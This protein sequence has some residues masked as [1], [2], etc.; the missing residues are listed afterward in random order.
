MMTEEEPKTNG[1]GTKV[2]PRRSRE[3][4]AD[5]KVFVYRLTD[6]KPREY[7]S[8]PESVV[9]EPLERRLLPFLEERNAGAGDYKIE[10]RKPN[11]RFERSYDFTIASDQAEP[12][13]V[14][15]VDSEYLNDDASENS[16]ER[17]LDEGEIELRAELLTL[18]RELRELRD[19]EKE[20]VGNAK[21]SQSEMLAM[22]RESAKQSEASFQRGL[23]MAKMIMQSSQPREDATSQ[24]MNIL[25]K[26]LG[27]VTKAKAI[28]EEIAPSD[29]GS[30]GGGGLLADGAKLL[31]SVGRNAGTLLPV[32][33]GFLSRPAAVSQPARVAPAPPAIQMSIPAVDDSGELNDLAAKIRQKKANS[34]VEEHERQDPK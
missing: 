31:D 27:I 15:D 13:R 18:R 25:E 30:G 26:S 3:P 33:G 12:D 24:A 19:K 10:I 16:Y 20:R 34:E 22:M 14:I 6:G 8:F 29:S 23:E 4:K 32:L 7:G 1:D 28:S 5:R 2:R 21:D 9:G 11:G 17:G